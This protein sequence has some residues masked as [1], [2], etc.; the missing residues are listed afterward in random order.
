MTE[1][2]P[3]SK[4]PHSMV[5]LA[6]IRPRAGRKFR[7]EMAT[8]RYPITSAN[9]FSFNATPGWR[10]EVGDATANGTFE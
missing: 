10:A 4:Q 9:L 6:L 1:L 7:E 5:T 3:S 8:Q 2:M